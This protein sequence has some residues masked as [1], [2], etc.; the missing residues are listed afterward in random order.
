[1]HKVE[2]SSGGDP[3]P[4]SNFKSTLS[5]AQKN[6]VRRKLASDTLFAPR[7]RC[8]SGTSRGLDPSV[9]STVAPAICSIPPREAL[10]ALPVFSQASSCVFPFL[11]G[12]GH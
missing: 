9:V 3:G 7:R 8:G 2:A 12:T 1:M 6:K 10:P 11:N 5:L 4:K